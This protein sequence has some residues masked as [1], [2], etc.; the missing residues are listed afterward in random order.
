MA[1]DIDFVR[2]TVEQLQPLSFQ[3]TVS[4]TM[5]CPHCKGTA[6]LIGAIDDDKGELCKNKP[7]KAKFW[8]HDS[9][10]IFIYVC[11]NCLKPTGELTQA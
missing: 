11:D 8:P 1:K 2:G 7:D 9:C 5:E 10:S 3:G 6:H 4:E